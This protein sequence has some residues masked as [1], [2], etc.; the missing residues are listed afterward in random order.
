MG[1]SDMPAGIDTPYLTNSPIAAPPAMSERELVAL[2]VLAAKS[3]P[4]AFEPLYR[5]HVD[6]V[7][8]YCYRRLRAPEA[9]ADTTS[10]IFIKAFT[11]LQ[12][13]NELRF[14]SWLFSIAHNAL[15]DEYRAGHPLE[16]LDEVLDLA[17]SEPSPEDQAITAEEKVTVTGLLRYLTPDQRQIVELRL[18]GLNGNEIAEVL[19]RS[20]GSIDT[21]QSRAIARLRSVV[22]GPPASAMDREARDGSR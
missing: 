12:S 9:A 3:D 13:C 4:Q 11:S 1:S 10:Q 8:R 16:S 21:A 5:G 6:D 22:T 18:A 20:R 17:S 15:I 2:Q 19:G 7:Y 14:R